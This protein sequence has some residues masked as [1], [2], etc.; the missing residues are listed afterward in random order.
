MELRGRFQYP[1]GGARPRELYFD[2]MW[3]VTTDYPSMRQSKHIYVG[4][5]RV[6]TRCNIEG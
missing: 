2:A 1:S 6:A 4:E 3:Q 5:T